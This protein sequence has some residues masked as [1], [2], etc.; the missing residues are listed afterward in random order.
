MKL[1]EAFSGSEM[2]TKKRGKF[3]TAGENG[4]RKR[5]R[6]AVG[7]DQRAAVKFLHCAGGLSRRACIPSTSMFLC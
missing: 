3:L 2:Y 5:Q 6:N 4:K 1:M 7:I